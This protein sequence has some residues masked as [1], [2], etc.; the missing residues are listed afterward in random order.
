MHQPKGYNEAYKSVQRSAFVQGCEELAIDYIVPQYEHDPRILNAIDLANLYPVWPTIDWRYCPIH[1]LQD[2][3][4]FNIPSIEL[5]L[6][7]DNSI[8]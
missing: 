2:E 3:V 5:G 4:R 6:F 8:Y 7:R 1:I